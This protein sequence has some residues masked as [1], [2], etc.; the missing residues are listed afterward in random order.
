MNTD[1]IKYSVPT[2]TMNEQ[3]DSYVFKF[4]VPGIGKADADLNVEGRTLTLKTHASWQAP[5]GFKEVVREF[6]RENYACS[7]DLPERVDPATLKAT[8][9][10][11]ILEVTMM[12]R[13]ETQPRRIAIG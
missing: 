9:E 12:K 11:G 7:V 8:L 3:P 13:P 6:A 10:N 1:N 4:T 5:A 2:V